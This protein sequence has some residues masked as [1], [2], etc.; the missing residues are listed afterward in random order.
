MLKYKIEQSDFETLNEVEQ[1]FYKQEGD[2]YQ[3]LVE[4]ATDKNKLDKF[5]NNNIEL[6]KQLDQ[7]KGVDLEEINKLKEQQ[8]QLRDKELI[9]K[10][11]F[12]TLIA[13]RTKAIQSDYEAKLQNLSSELEC[14]KGQYTSLVTKHE[15]GGAT[16]SAFAKHKISPE[17]FEAVT[18]QINSR[19]TVD[20]GQVV[21]KEG[22]QIVTGANGNLTI[23]EFVASMPD[24]FK[25]QSTGGK[26][27]GA[28]E[29]TGMRQGTSSQDKI[30][31][32]LGKM[33][34]R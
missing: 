13:E 31:S 22:D 16:Q 12:D 24:I 2:T 8:R 29:S 18:A 4:G 19:F 27:R 20:N 10:K 26:A 11:D 17:A 23:D 28:T 33:L 25:V 9:D 14:T 15:I 32:G 5:R 7:F 1:T 21:A 6:S 3:L 30:K 34:N